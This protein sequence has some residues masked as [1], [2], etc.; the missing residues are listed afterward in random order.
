VFIELE[1]LEFKIPI[2]C[3]VTG[4]DITPY[5]STSHRKLVRIKCGSKRKFTQCSELK[6]ISNSTI[7][8]YFSLLLPCDETL[9]K[10]AR[11]YKCIGFEC[12]R[13]LREDATRSP[14]APEDR[15]DVALGLAE[16]VWMGIEYLGCCYFKLESRKRNW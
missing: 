9:P 5:D 11:S 10:L 12:S 3:L 15:L 4:T 14:Q 16:F 7:R 8:V 6:P 13:A 2:V 1:S